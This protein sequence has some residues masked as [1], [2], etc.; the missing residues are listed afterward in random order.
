[1]LFGQ[2]LVELTGDGGCEFA[3]S[4]G[5]FGGDAE[6]AGLVA[7]L[8][9]GRARPGD[10]IADLAGSLGGRLQ[11]ED[12]LAGHQLEG[13]RLGANGL[14]FE[15]GGGGGGA[16]QI[17]HRLD[18]I[19]RHAGHGGP[20]GHPG[21]GQQDDSGANA[22]IDGGDRQFLEQFEHC[23]KGSLICSIIMG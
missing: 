16:L 11:H 17:G 9:D 20:T 3:E 6:P 7:E 10:E 22:Q 4:A 14:A 12:A 8:A 2:Q 19:G 21:H 5:V 23:R 15:V 18:R 1:M 13:E